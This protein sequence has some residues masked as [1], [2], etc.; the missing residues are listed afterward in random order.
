MRAVFTVLLKQGPAFRAYI[1]LSCG[2]RSHKV[3]CDS[4]GSHFFLHF[5]T[6]SRVRGWPPTLGSPFLSVVTSARESRVPQL[7]HCATL[8]KSGNQELRL[9]RTAGSQSYLTGKTQPMAC[10]L[11]F[12]RRVGARV[13]GGC[14]ALQDTPF[15]RGV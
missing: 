4:S 14:A 15:A 8:S 1:S 10:L 2:L 12:P 7:Q 6:V 13:I 3:S 11:V 5:C 9:P